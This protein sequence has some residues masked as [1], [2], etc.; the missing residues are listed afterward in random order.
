MDSV[1]LSK[2]ASI[3]LQ[4]RGLPDLVVDQL[5][6][7]GKYISRGNVY[8]VIFDK[9]SIKNIRKYGGSEFVSLVNKK[10]GNA[11]LILG[12]DNTLITAGWQYGKDR[13]LLDGY[14]SNS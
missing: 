6:D 4:Q 9:K 13:F 8:T 3:R 14:R 10:Y 12:K 11:Y 1:R 2:H 7:F 5:L